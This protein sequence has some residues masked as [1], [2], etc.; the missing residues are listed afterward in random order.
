[1]LHVDAGVAVLDGD[2]ILANASHWLVQ[3]EAA[4]QQGAVTFDLAGLGQIDSA[5]LSLILSLRRRAEAAGSSIEFR[6]L[7]DSLIS[8]A[9]LYGV[10]DQI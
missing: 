3:G 5:A 6:N 1:M 4:L 2:L 8:L 10:D 7:P 9:K